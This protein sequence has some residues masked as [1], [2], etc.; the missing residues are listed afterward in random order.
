MRTS[1]LA[2]VPDRSSHKPCQSSSSAQSNLDHP[3]N[4][5]KISELAARFLERVS[6]A[7]TVLFPLLDDFAC[8]FTANLEFGLDVDAVPEN[9]MDHAVQRQYLRLE[10]FLVVG[11][12]ARLTGTAIGESELGLKLVVAFVV[13]SIRVSPNVTTD[14]FNG[15]GVKQQ[16]KSCIVVSAHGHHSA[17]GD[18]VVEMDIVLGRSPPRDHGIRTSSRTG[19]FG[20]ESSGILNRIL[21]SVAFD[22][23]GFSRRKCLPARIARTAHS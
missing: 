1:C 12:T 23:E 20:R 7:R 11:D 16:P 9:A 3:P 13:D 14:T 18:V 10:L 4:A 5:G 17:A 22:V 15:V 21:A 2:L 8:L 19:A 6:L